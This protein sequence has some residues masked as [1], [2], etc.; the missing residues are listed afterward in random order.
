VLSASGMPQFGDLVAS[1]MRGVVHRGY[2][3]WQR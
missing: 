3:T 1:R 2:G